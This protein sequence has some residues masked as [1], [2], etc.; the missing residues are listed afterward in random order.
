MLLDILFREYEILGGNLNELIWI[1]GMEVFLILEYSH[2]LLH[3]FRLIMSI[4]VITLS[5][6]SFLIL[7]MAN[8]VLN[9]VFN[10]SFQ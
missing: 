6:S 3:I 5:I 4:I 2:S 8:A 10:Y 7:M 9:I 1:I